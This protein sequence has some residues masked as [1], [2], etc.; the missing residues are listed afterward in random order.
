MSQVEALI[1]PSVLRWA[2][3]RAGFSLSQ[4]A[5]KLKRS[6]EEIIAWESGEKR[7]TITQARNA[8]ELYK[9]PLAVFYLPEPPIDF[10]TLRDFRKLPNEDIRMFNKEL[11]DVIRTAYEH[12]HWV[13]EFLR[14]EGVSSLSFVGTATLH[15]N[16]KSVAEQILNA[17]EISPD[18]QCKTQ[19]RYYALK[20][21]IRKVESKGVYI[22]RGGNIDLNSCRGFVLSDNVAPFI[23]LNSDDA[24]AAMMFTLIHELA[25]LWLNLSGVS[26]LNSIGTFVTLE[27]S[28]IEMFCNQ[29][30]SETLI[31]SERFETELNKLSTTMKIEDRI[32]RISRIFKVSE[33]AIARKM[34]QYGNISNKKYEELRQY[35]QIRWDDLKRIREEKEKERDGGPSFYVTKLSHNGYLYTQTVIG[36]YLSGKVSGRDASSLLG[37]KLN[38]FSKLAAQ[39]GIQLW[40]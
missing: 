40:N 2:R 25:H 16:P 24:Y 3:E 10:D 30:A 28:N 33:E 9:R 37:V 14:E 36:A 15:D 6:Q 5:T 11:L 29:V 8:S 13:K 4:A 7:P 18:E 35:Y 12:Q 1:T 39:A 38:H 23:Y 31:Y 17:F 32:E 19:S 27:D 34:L 20:L 26:N 22:F 21:W